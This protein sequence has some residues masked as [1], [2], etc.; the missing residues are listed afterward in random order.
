M[1]IEGFE[2]FALLGAENTI[3]R[4]LP[5]LCICTYHT[6]EDSWEIPLLINR[7]NSKYKIYLRHHRKKSLR[8]TVCYAYVE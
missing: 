1:D 3:S 4:Q 5:L 8:E 2:K 6:I 7:F